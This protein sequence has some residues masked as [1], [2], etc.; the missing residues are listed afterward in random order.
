[1]P[2]LSPSVVQVVS[3]TR[4]EKV[5]QPARDSA[6]RSSTL[7]DAYII[8]KEF[9]VRLH[10]ALKQ[11]PLTFEER[12]QLAGALLTARDKLQDLM[13]EAGE[14]RDHDGRWFIKQSKGWAEKLAAP[15]FEF[16][17]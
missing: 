7:I 11:H 17:D 9:R 6:D 16:P 2:Q 3:H 15:E 4:L 10:D 1:M 14:T 5:G 8:F 13:T 12:Q